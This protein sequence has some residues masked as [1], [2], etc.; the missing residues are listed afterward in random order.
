MF[1]KIIISSFALLFLTNCNAQ[2]DTKNPEKVVKDSSKNTEGKVIYFNEGENKFLKEYEMNITFKNISEDSRCP[3]GT[4]CIWQGVAIANVELMGTSTRPMMLQLATMEN[5]N[6]NYHKSVVFNGY[7]ITMTSVN[8]HPKANEST[9]SLNGKYK[10]GLVISKATE[11][12][13]TK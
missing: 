5:A 6:K 2:K 10:I 11:N 7:K 9:K 1:Y 3:E 8:P 4:T 13:T 12:T